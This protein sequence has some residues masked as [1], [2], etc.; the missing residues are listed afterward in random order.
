MQYIKFEH[1][2]INLL[3]LSKTEELHVRS[4]QLLNKHHI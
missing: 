4:R 3:N 1:G 2:G